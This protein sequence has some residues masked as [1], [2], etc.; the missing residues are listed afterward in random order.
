MRLEYADL[1]HERQ[2]DEGSIRR[3]EAAQAACPCKDGTCRDCV[4]RQFA[5]TLARFQKLTQR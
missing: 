1:R 3:W 2:L 4:D 5:R